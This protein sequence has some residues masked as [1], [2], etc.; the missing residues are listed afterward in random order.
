MHWN[1]TMCSETPPEA[2]YLIA[3]IMSAKDNIATI[4]NSDVDCVDYSTHT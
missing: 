3:L 1:T 2:K 4:Q